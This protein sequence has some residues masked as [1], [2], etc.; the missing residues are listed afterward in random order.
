MRG[1]GFVNRYDANTNLIS[2]VGKMKFFA[3]GG[4]NN[5]GSNLGNGGIN[6][7]KFANRFNNPDYYDPSVEAAILIPTPRPFCTKFT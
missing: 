4:V 5:V 6:G 1:G 3:L 7:D 2:F